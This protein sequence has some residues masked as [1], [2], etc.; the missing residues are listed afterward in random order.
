M[1][2]NL[3]SLMSHSSLMHHHFSA[4]SDAWKCLR[5]KKVFSYVKQH[6]WQF[7]FCIWKFTNEA[8]GSSSC[9]Q[10]VHPRLWAKSR[11]QNCKPVGSAQKKIKLYPDNV[12]KVKKLKQSGSE[13]YTISVVWLP[14]NN[15]TLWCFTF[16]SVFC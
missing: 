4:S 13:T 12:I 2:G 3:L 5:L 1:H 15:V 14:V 9:A 10:R 7:D 11:Y 16:Y 8:W 6:F